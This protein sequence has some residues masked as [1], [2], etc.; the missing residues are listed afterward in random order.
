MTEDIVSRL[1]A[2]VAD[3][4][5]R[6][7]LAAWYRTGCVPALHGNERSTLA[8]AG[9]LAAGAAPRLSTTGRTVAYNLHEWK[10]QVEGGSMRE[11]CAALGVLP[12][13]FVADLG[14]G[15]G[16]TLLA[17]RTIAPCRVAGFD[18]D[19]DAVLL[20][21]AWM[22][23]LDVP[24]GSWQFRTADIHALPLAD[25][26]C[27]HVICR[28]VIQKLRVGRTLDEIGRVLR[29]GGKLFLHTLGA[30][31]YLDAARRDLPAFLV[32]CFALANGALFLA[33][34]AQACL[35]L[36]RRSLREVFLV[37]SRLREM[38]RARGLEPVRCETGRFAGLPSSIVMTAVKRPGAGGPP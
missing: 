17:C 30:G 26:S 1:A 16:Q 31:Y 5:L 19:P 33:A 25:A 10:L 4:A 18:R 34:G 36:G 11:E 37:P 9:L 29:P 28:V 27:T 13:S 6:D 24:A 38:L 23:A 7:L 22:R 14:C 21:R 12:S 32:S 2:V 3:P 35:R 15:G 20:A 8:A